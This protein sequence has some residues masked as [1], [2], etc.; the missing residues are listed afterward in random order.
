MPLESFIHRWPLNVP[1]KFYVSA[2][3]IDCALCRDTI[4]TV[5]QSESGWSYVHRQPETEEEME[6]C[7]EVVDG[8]PLGV[9][10]ADGDRFDWEEIP[11]VVDRERLLGQ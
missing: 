5:F 2:G 4:P 6:L 1:G 9:V 11:S 10:H 3:C 8:C 7:R